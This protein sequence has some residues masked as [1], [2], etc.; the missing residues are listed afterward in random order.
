MSRSANFVAPLR[1][2][3]VSICE[4]DAQ[5][6]LCRGCR[7]TLNE[8]ARWSSMTEAERDQVLAALPARVVNG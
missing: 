2:P 8:I 7:R 3:C 4:M 5:S 1:S 6:G